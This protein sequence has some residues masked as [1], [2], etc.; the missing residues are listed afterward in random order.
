MQDRPKPSEAP[1][2]AGDVRKTGTIRFEV[3]CRPEVKADFEQATA[4]LHSFFYEEA[5]QRFLSIAE[6]DPECA[7]AWWGVAMTWYH[8]LWAPP[9]PGGDGERAP[10][11]CEKAKKLGGKTELETRAHRGHRRLLRAPTTRRSRPSRSLESCHGPRSLSARA[12][13][14]RAGDRALRKPH[15]DDLEVKTSRAV[16]AR[17][18]ASDRQA[19]PEPARGGRDPRAALREEPGPSRASPHYIIHAYDYPSL[20]AP[21]PRSRPALRRDR[22]LGA[23][24]AAHA[25]AHL[26]AH[27][28][29]EG[30]HRVE[31]RLRLRRARLR[32]AL[33]WRRHDD[34]TSCTRWTTW[35]RAT[36]RRDRSAKAAEILEHL[37]KIQTFHPAKNFAAAYAVGAIP[38]RWTLERRRW[39]EAAALEM[40]HP[41]SLGRFPFAEAHIEFARAVGAARS[42][43]GSRPPARRCARLEQLREALKEPKFQ[44]WINQIEIQRLAA[45]GW[46]ALRRGAKDEAEA[47]PAGGG[48]PRGPSRH[49]PGHAGTDPP[50][51]GAARRSPP[52]ARPSRGGAGGIREVARGVPQPL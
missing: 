20:A 35:I 24:R 43:D 5:R 18:G 1:P 21:R 42:G 11:P 39:T 36:C 44:W 10:R 47:L 15:P 13:C 27:G 12:V 32:G 8:P 49:P 31:P 7:M 14:F 29:V 28:D 26:H 41:D 19:V 50:R 40:R 3:S 9:T 25:V 4:L 22:A 33:P 34:T 48:R 30:I 45:A 2:K 37:A 17:D 46:L 51:A 52:G 16:A 23:A 38:A 6:R